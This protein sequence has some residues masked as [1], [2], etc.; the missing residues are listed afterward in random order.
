MNANE[1]I[2]ADIA[3][4][5]ARQ[6]A[7]AGLPV[8]ARISAEVAARDADALAHYLAAHVGAFNAVEVAALF[9]LPVDDVRAAYATHR[10][11]QAWAQAMRELETAQGKPADSD[12]EGMRD[13]SSYDLFAW[14]ND[15]EARVGLCVDSFR[16]EIFDY[17][18]WRDSALAESVMRE[19]FPDAVIV[20]HDPRG[21]A[22]AGAERETKDAGEWSPVGLYL[23]ESGTWE[24]HTGE[25]YVSVCDGAGNLDRALAVA[26]LRECAK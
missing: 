17:C 4:R 8:A 26:T 20:P 10:T 14:V 23:D 9:N 3:A 12:D 1:K 2:A 25:E 13:A 11:A 19:A 21:S 22:V 18:D 5:D 7:Q 6:R 16:H 24:V 15:L